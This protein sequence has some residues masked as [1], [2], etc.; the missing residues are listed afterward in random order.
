[1]PPQCLLACWPF[2]ASSSS[3]ARRLWPADDHGGELLDVVP[4]PDL[5][6]RRGV[7]RS[8]LADLLADL[9]QV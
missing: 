6:D 8:A 2:F 4:G 1:M 5:R 9:I 7:G 3:T